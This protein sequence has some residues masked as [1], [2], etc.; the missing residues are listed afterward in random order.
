MFYDF[1]VSYGSS[2]S[3]PV[4]VTVYKKNGSD[5][6]DIGCVGISRAIDSA[7][8]QAFKQLFG[9]LPDPAERRIFLDQVRQ[10]E[11]LQAQP[12]NVGL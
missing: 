5:H 3:T 7:F 4:V 1:F 6:L 10:R 9:R 8:G 2:L 11:S 12:Q